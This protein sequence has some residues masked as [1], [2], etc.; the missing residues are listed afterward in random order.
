MYKFKKN[1]VN[2]KTKKLPFMMQC[3]YKLKKQ[4]IINFK[5]YLNILR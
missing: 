3:N 2:N 1:K 5:S 4:D